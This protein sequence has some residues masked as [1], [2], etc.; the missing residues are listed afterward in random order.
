MKNY[1]LTQKGKIVFTGLFIALIVALVL[2]VSQFNKNI[3]S[4]SKERMINTGEIE[5][6]EDVI[7][8]STMDNDDIMVETSTDPSIEV[9]TVTEK[10][11]VENKVDENDL[12]ILYTLYYAPDGYNISEKD[13][14]I[15]DTY[16]EL[17]IKNN[18]GIIIEGNY[19]LGKNYV[20]KMFE[21]L[22]YE[23]AVNVKEYLVKKG[24][25]ENRITIID[26]KNSKPLNK[27]RSN[28]EVGLNRRVDIY[29]EDFYK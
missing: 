20:E 8:D 11:E 24:I 5:K 19:H 10:S 25:D 15:L 26:N 21:H 23:R 7:E 29:F 6:T 16:Y 2:M 27:D 28:F 22:S 9:E 17:A 3:D 4:V 12:E 13:I 1:R 14:V 18:S